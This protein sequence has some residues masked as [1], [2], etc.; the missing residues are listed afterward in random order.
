MPLAGGPGVGCQLSSLLLLFRG[1]GQ[2]HLR[3][4]PPPI[5]NG[6]LAV[7]VMVLLMLMVVR[8]EVM[9]QFRISRSWTVLGWTATAV[10]AVA[11]AFFIASSA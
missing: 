1:Q 7:P 4:P 5:V 11:S 9:G 6:V 10:M 2:R 8:E 3:R